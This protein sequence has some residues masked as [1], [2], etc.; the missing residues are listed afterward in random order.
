MSPVRRLAT[1]LLSGMLRGGSPESREWASAM[2]RELDF[3]ENDWAALLWAVGG[4]TAILGRSG[5][6]KIAGVLAGIA[7]ATLLTAGAFGAFAL[8]FHFFPHSVEH[9]MPWAVWLAVVGLPLA[10]FIVVARILWRNRRPMAV[11]MLL[12][13]SALTAHVVVHM[14]THMAKHSG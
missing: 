2:R 4:T 10:I 1:R 12:S 6:K 7:I 9:S 8:A 3:I 13:A 14:A 5:G 11:G